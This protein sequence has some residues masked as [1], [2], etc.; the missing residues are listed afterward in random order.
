MGSLWIENL[1]LWQFPKGDYLLLKPPRRENKM[2]LFSSWPEQFKSNGALLKLSLDV[3]CGHLSN[4]YVRI[5]GL[6]KFVTWKSYIWYH[7]HAFTLH[8]YDLTDISGGG[9]NGVGVWRQGCQATDCSLRQCF[10]I[11]KNEIGYLDLGR[12]FSHISG[13]K[14]RCLKPKH[15]RYR[16]LT[17]TLVP[18]YGDKKR[19][20]DW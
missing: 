12:I 18:D 9:G 8:V 15:D 20:I 10:N 14:T 7:R 3:F 2:N 1:N 19:M 4:M 13:I 6:P 16:T 11:C 5:P 17:L